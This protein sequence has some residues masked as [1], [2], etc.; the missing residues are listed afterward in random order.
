MIPSVGLHWSVLNT[1]EDL[2][3]SSGRE[4]INRLEKINVGVEIRAWV[5][6]F[7]ID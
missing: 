6:L 1:K 2:P 7:V 5:N 3:F 4:I